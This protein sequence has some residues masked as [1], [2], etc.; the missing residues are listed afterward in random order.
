MAMFSKKTI[1][2]HLWVQV[3]ILYLLFT[4]K[5]QIYKSSDFVAKIVFHTVLHFF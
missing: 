1:V 5:S 4:M 3:M 2:R